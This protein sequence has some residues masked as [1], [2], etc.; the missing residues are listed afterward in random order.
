LLLDRVEQQPIYYSDNIPVYEV[1][2]WHCELHLWFVMV[3]DPGRVVPQ[4]AVGFHPLHSKEQI[5]YLIE[6]WRK[7]LVG[8]GYI[9]G[10]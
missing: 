1:W 3:A 10:A 4:G 6:E 7:Y 2:F 8:T 5:K 9:R